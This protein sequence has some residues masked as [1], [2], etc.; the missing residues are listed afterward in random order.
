LG[1]SERL[2]LSFLAG[3][4]AGQVLADGVAAFFQDG[5]SALASFGGCL[6]LGALD[7]ERFHF[8]DDLVEGSLV[9]KDCFLGGC[10]FGL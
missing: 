4:D 3:F 10:I 8:I 6:V 1:H 7:R 5:F 9:F 2:A